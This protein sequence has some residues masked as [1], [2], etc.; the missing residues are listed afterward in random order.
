MAAT[1]VILCSC[2]ASSP[3]DKASVLA[4]LE[5][6]ANDGKVL[7]GHQDD[8]CY[9]HSWA[10]E[11][12]RSDV[13]EVCGSMPAVLGFD[14]GGIELGSPKNLDDVPFELI[15]QESIR[16]YEAGGVVTFSW[17]VRNPLT[18]GD[19]WDVSSAEVVGNVL[20]GA[21]KEKFQE[22][23]GRLA[24]FLGS[25][26][27][28]DGTQVPVIFRPWHEHT[29]SWFWWGQDL[30]SKEQYTALW[31]LTYDYI[32]GQ[33]GL[34]EL[35]WA[36]SP[37]AGTDAEGYMERYPGDA[38]VDILGVDCYQYGDNESYISLVKGTL[39][40]MADLGRQ[41]GK[42][43]ALTETGYEGI[44]YPKWWTEV[45]LPAVSEAPV[46]YLLVWRNAH[47]KPGHFYG[48]WAGCA[49]EEDFKAFYDSDETVFLKDLN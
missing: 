12:G 42:T 23:L 20:D 44:P 40:Y 22:W 45:L 18:G 49:T 16:H 1:A 46:A 24:D 17:H 10:W 21:C 30:C 8:P 27:T 4:S 41:H 3:K 13:K 31:Q 7:F 19:S 15:R 32:V 43:I 25:L 14:L 28:A 5:T 33:R 35:I 37:G 39:A 2:A 29:G 26:K 34:S 48:P 9:G 6:Y 11:S 38:V 47:D 36:Y